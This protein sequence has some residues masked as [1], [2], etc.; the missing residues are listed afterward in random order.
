MGD[1]PHGSGYHR[2]DEIA[3]YPSLPAKGLVASNIV[4]ANS[5]TRTATVNVTVT[6]TI[7]RHQDIS[8]KC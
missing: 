2:R 5:L 3:Y 1:A 7:A 4:D 6:N 8:T